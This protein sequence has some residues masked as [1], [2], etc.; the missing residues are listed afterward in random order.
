MQVKVC[1]L[2]ITVRSGRERLRELFVTITDEMG[3]ANM[4]GWSCIYAKA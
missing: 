1:G 2:I 4:A 3:F